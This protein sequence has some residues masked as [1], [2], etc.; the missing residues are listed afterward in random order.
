MAIFA[1]ERVVTALLYDHCRHIHD[2][3]TRTTAI[4]RH[5]KEIQSGGVPSR[6]GTTMNRGVS[7][8]GDRGDGRLK[9]WHDRGEMQAIPEVANW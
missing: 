3:L 9:P 8:A 6:I 7:M 2:E 4:A 1:H 5:F